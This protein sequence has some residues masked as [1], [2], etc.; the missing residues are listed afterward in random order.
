MDRPE[1]GRRAVM[2]GLAAAALASGAGGALAR[3][4][5]HR[6]FF[7]RI[8]KPVGLQLYALGDE[9]KNDLDAALAR[10]AQI[11]YRE[12]ELS[13][14]YGRT[15]AQMRAAADRAGLGIGAMQIMAASLPGNPASLNLNSEPQRLADTLGELGAR[16]VNLTIAPFPQGMK[17]REGENFRDM[18]SRCFTEAG[19]DHWK[20]VAA[21][22]N[23][24]AALLKPLGIMLGYHNHNIEFAPIGRTTG[25]D[26]LV[27]ETDPGLV[28]FE[29][30]IGWVA[31]AGLDPVDFLRRHRGRMR[32]M[33]VKDVKADNIPNFALATSPCE[34]GSGRLDWARILPA[35]HAAGVQHYFVEQEPPFA[36]ARMEAAATSYAFLAALRA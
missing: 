2:A 32:W 23:E 17:P 9:P 22:L 12:I 20:R 4:G 35:A 13:Q 10:L 8:G 18:I 14:F 3:R 28:F 7:Q 11:G 29:A 5:P 31:S 19:E 26:V 16:A 1:F 6:P 24:R 34:V 30:D 15:P 27:R 25:W 33:H 21:T 36:V